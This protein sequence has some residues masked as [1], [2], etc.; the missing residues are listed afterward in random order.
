M[1]EQSKIE[2]YRQTKAPHEL[3]E[4][5]LET[6]QTKSVVSTNLSLYKTLSAVAACLILILSGTAFGNRSDVSIRLNGEMLSAQPMVVAEANADAVAMQ[7]LAM[8]SMERSMPSEMCIPL[9]VET[10]QET[11][12]TISNGAMHI[13]ASDSGELLYV[14]TAYTVYEA[15]SVEWYMDDEQAATFC[16]TSGNEECLVELEYDAERAEWLICQK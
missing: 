6:Y 8:A 13:F 16:A 12:I 15:V 14:G 10:T 3:K 9:T 2:A 4:R 7:G 1:F 5:V 11:T